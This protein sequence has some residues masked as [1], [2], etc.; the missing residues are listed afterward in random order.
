MNAEEQPAMYGA[1]G[2]TSVGQVRDHNED[3]FICDSSAGI[4]LVADGMGGHESGEVASHI[5]CEEVPT[6]IKKGSSPT[7]AL[8]AAHKSIK[9]APD[10]GKG[11]KGMGTTAVLAFASSNELSVTW[12]GDSRAYLFSD[13][14]LTQLTKDHS[15]VQHLLDSGAISEEEAENH[16]EK[17]VITQCL[18]TESLDEVSVDEVATQ[19]Y[20]NEK[21]L[22]CSDGLTGEVEDS[23]ITEILRN[24]ANIDEASNNLIAAANKNGGSD[25]ITVVLIEAPSNSPQRPVAAK[26]KKMKAISVGSQTKTGKRHNVLAAAI[27]IVLAVLLSLAAISYFSPSS[28]ESSTVQSHASGTSLPPFKEGNNSAALT[29][30]TQAD[31][32]DAPPPFHA[33]TTV[34][35]EILPEQSEDKLDLGEQEVE[36]LVD[37]VEINQVPP[38]IGEI[39]T[40]SKDG[41]KKSLETEAEKLVDKNE[42]E[43]GVTDVDPPK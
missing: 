21:L 42:E 15:F 32:S 22:L 34:E 14:H 26:T 25:N 18:G 2:K 11:S 19:L 10:S 33:E 31:I 12:V 30:K 38:E 43:K 40:E 29:S 1:V 4:W 6:L 17:N 20:S 24:S 23:E 41:I 35:Q 13:N 5:A 16:P 37:D 27:G 9:S 7:E 8:Q 28:D 3:S 39:L 36:Q